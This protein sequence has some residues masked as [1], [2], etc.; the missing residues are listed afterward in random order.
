MELRLIQ[1]VKKHRTIVENFSYM[2]VLQLFLLIYPL[3]TYPYLVQVLG[4]ELYGIVLTAQML[5]SYASLIVDFGS[6]YVCAKHVSI[7]RDNKDK[8][9]EILSNVLFVRL[10]LFV[11][12]FF[13]YGAVVFIIPTY[14][15][16]YLLFLLTYGFVSNELLFPQ[17][18]FQGIEKM[19]LISIISIITKLVFVGF[20][21]LI[22]NGPED[23]NMVP[24]V[25]SLG[26]LISGIVS[27]WIII[28]GMK[29]KLV[30]PS[31]KRSFFYF[32][33]SLPILSTDLI[34]SIKD[35]FSYFLIGSYVGMADVVVYDLGLKLNGIVSKPYLLISTVLFPSSARK[36]S[37][38]Q[39]KKTIVITFV[40][41]LFAVLLVNVFLNEIVLFFLHQE[42]DLI[43]IRC[44]LFA[45]I[46]LSVS[47]ILATNC[48]V[49][50]GYNR[51]ML[52]SII[53]TTAVYLFSLLVVLVTGKLNCIMSFIAIAI[54]SFV[55]ELLYRIIKT[56]TIVKKE[57]LID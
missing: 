4:S 36:K 11:F 13:I 27:L 7:N 23:V 8:L 42:I 17:F 51:L 52:N 44:F 6:N 15:E 43:P 41:T 40:C 31:L 35:K 2:S 28:G 3:I 1:L 55:A 33:D 16:Y 21:F 19:K 30:R 12:V 9:S 24:L 47:Y 57:K 25:Y 10:I 56:Y 29:I 54:I 34:C 37:I 22:I 32:K 20:I 46:I 14:R 45:P 48:F 50:F 38:N 18:F 53:V 39:L 49:A 5:S 26:F